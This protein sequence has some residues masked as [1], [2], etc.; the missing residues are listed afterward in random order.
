MA[1]RLLLIDNYDSFTWN[2]AQA[3]L[4]LGAEVEVRRNDQITVEQARAWGPTHVCISPG[5]GHPHDAGVSMEMIRA[6]LDGTPLLGVC[7][8]HQALGAA[9]GATVARAPRL[10]HGKSS[11]VRHDG[12][13]LYA[14]LPMPMQVARY[15]SLCVVR[16][17]LPP[18]LVVTSETIDQGEIMGLAHATLP[19]FGV[20]YH[21]ESVLTPEGNQ[22]LANFLATPRGGAR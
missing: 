13:G 19:V 14:G 2:L 7:L 6:Y 9:L 15:H 10:M 22:L 5:P 4:M 16:D 12:T 20:Q 8:G 18:E 3:F 1:P 21:P 11:L 17:T